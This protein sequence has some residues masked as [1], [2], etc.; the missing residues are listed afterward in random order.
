MHIWQNNYISFGTKEIIMRLYERAEEFDLMVTINRCYFDADQGRIKLAIDRLKDLEEELGEKP[1]IYYT[2]GMLRKDSLGQGINAYRCF[3]KAV[4]MDSNYENA[5]VNAA[6][7]APGEIEFRRFARKAFDL[8]LNESS[9]FET[10][11][12]YID[13]KNEPYWQI[14][15]Q[16]ITSEGLNPDT[17]AHIQLG[18]STAKLPQD[19]ELNYRRQR[20]QILRQIDENDQKK[21]E[22]MGELFPSD[23]RLALHEALE[24]LE[25]SITLDP[26]DATFWNFK[27]AW[28]RLLGRF[29]EALTAADEA[30]MLRP[31]GYHLPYYN[32]AVIFAKLGKKAEA[33]E[34]AQKALEQIEI[35][36]KRDDI[37]AIQ[38]LISNTNSTSQTISLIDFLPVLEHICKAAQIISNQE[39]GLLQGIQPGQRSNLKE[40]VKLVQK[41][42]YSRHPSPE[43]ALD[44]VPAMAE[45]LSYFTPETLFIS[46]HQILLTDNIA[47]Q[48][49]L[50]ATIYIA[51]YGPKVMQRD[52]IRLLILVIFKNALPPASPEMIRDQYRKIILDVS[53][54]GTDKMKNLDQLMRVE[55]AKIH[56]ELPELIADQEPSTAWEIQKAQESILDK[57]QG[58]PYIVKSKEKGNQTQASSE[59]SNNF[60]LY[61]VIGIICF[62]IGAFISAS[63]LI[64]ITVVYQTG[65][66]EGFLL[67]LSAII[68]SEYYFRENEPNKTELN[69]VPKLR[70]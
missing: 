70:D 53:T 13:E 61:V 41:A 67:F 10:L 7:Y 55:L 14:L 28:C 23:E 65:L 37:T 40:M 6:I 49:S 60:C 68:L 34:Q 3:S 5:I 50:K 24:E 46:L 33:I 45:L 48:N 52:A 2:E 31:K 22:S 17:A 21:R 1:K 19:E 42:I 8:S 12:K 62:G 18:L 30:I 54:T 43:N 57:L 35:S 25:K 29:E 20:F 39:I 36:G 66:L 16:S 4:D 11:L 64:G 69:L 9:H 32:K 63:M 51:A 26:Y 56:P 58:T 44:Y 15:L 27:S 47:F 38:Q 59:V